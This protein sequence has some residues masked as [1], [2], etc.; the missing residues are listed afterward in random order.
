[1]IIGDDMSVT[2]DEKARSLPATFPW[3]GFFLRWGKP[4]L[5]EETLALR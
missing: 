4:K 5:F 3:L 2:R 1:M